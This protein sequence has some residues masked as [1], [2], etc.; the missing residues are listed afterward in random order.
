[1]KVLRISLTILLLLFF[2][3]SSNFNPTSSDENSYYYELGSQFKT[4]SHPQSLVIDNANQFIYILCGSLHSVDNSLI[5]QKYN[6]DGELLNTIIDFSDYSFGLYQRYS[7]IDLTIDDENNICV[8]AKPYRKAEVDEY[9]EAYDGFTILLHNGNGDFIR[10]L[11]YKN[12]SLKLNP[13]AITFKGD[14]FYVINSYSLF[15]ISKVTDNLEEIPLPTDPD[16]NFP[17]NLI[18]DLAI[19]GENNIW[20][21]GQTTD[22]LPSNHSTPTNYIAKMD[23]GGN[24]LFKIYSVNTIPILHS[25]MSQPAITLNDGNAIFI[26]TFYCK[27]LEIYDT[28]G[29]LLGDFDFSKEISSDVLPVDLVIDRSRNVYVLDYINGMVY[30]LINKKA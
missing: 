4:H 6:L 9:W 25:A 5:I 18:S 19:N 24:E 17:K 3:C 14:F 10:E 13:E 26:T 2:G 23:F 21:V 22:T 28:S 11:D 29:V 20:F 30:K 7:P 27:S 8:L 15:E 16:S 1:M 12:I